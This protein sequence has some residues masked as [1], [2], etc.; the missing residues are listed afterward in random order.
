MTR[1]RLGSAPSAPKPQSCLGDLLALDRHLLS[2]GCSRSLGLGVDAHRG[3][4]P[5]CGEKEV[6]P[7]RLLPSYSVSRPPFCQTTPNHYYS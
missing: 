5:Q 7:R 2:L 3:S 1:N 6:I 4:V